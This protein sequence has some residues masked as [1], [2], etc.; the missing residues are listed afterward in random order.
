MRLAIAR[1]TRKLL[2]SLITVICCTTITAQQ[3][4]THPFPEAYLKLTSDT[5]RMRFLMKAISDSLDEGQLNSIY[6]WSVAGLAMAKKNANDTMIGI[7]YF[8]IGKAYAYKIIKPD[9]AVYF[10]K[11]V[12]PFFPDKLKYYNL[13]ATREIMER[14][15]EAGE[16]DSAMAWLDSLHARID[17]M[18]IDNPRRMNMSQNMAGVYRYF[19]MFKTATRLY[20][21]AI[22][23]YRIKKNKGGLGMAMANLGE[24]YDEAEDDVKAIRYSKEALGNLSIA[25]MPYMLTA[26]NLASYYG[27][28]GKYD[29]VKFYLHLSDSVARLMGDLVQ[30]KVSNPLIWSEAL[31]NQNKY[32][33]A[34]ELL[35]NIGPLLYQNSYPP[36]LVKFKLACANADTGM[37]RFAPARDSLLSALQTA[38]ESQQEIYIVLAL[39]GLAAVSA[40]MNNFKEGYQY[41]LQYMQRKDSLTNAETKARLADFEVSYQAKQKEEKIALLQ[42]E[43]DIK[44]LQLKSSRQTNILYGIVFL[45]V[46]T[47]LSVIFWQRSK[48]QRLETE[49]VKA[50]LQTQ[51]LR[52]QMNPHFIF[53]CLNS[54]ENFIMQNDKRMASDYLN[55]FSKLIRSILDSS[56]NEVVPLAKDMEALQLYVEL[57]QL[58][59][60]HKFSFT[61][62]VDPALKGGDYCVPSL[63]VQPFVE[64]AIV[65]G[66]AHSEEDDL[67][68]TVTAS[69]ENENIKYVVQ[70]NGIGRKKARTYQEL[71]KPYHKSVGLKITEERINMFNQQSRPGEFVAITDLYDGEEHPKGTKVEILLKAI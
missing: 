31:N 61:S 35:N 11:K 34:R 9:S 62:F 8:D 54:I 58:R 32:A 70:D 45:F 65:H 28:I 37:H 23:G 15:A 56:R 63:L 47:L 17:T 27:N 51:V 7:F 59:F 29:S 66:L 41:Q 6:D 24:L 12:L 46:L 44:N 55:K 1:V 13:Y 69:L 52:S 19:G 16:K 22:Q 64:N 33:Q 39:Q 60:N 30:E 50:E 40:K 53:N 68:L 3:A 20:E 14:Y 25:N 26:A 21:D 57:E 49:K 71:N 2:A 67:R 4:S 18:K 42:Q 10:Y 48:R 43:N 36:G 5:A 38:K